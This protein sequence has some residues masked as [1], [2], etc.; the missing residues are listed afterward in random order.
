MAAEQVKTALDVT[1]VAGGFGTWLSLLPDI[2][3][4][5]SIAWLA[6]RIWESETIKKLLKRR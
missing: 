6:L 5:L 2:A 4:L 3:A 1:A